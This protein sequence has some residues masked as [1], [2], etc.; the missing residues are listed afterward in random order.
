[1]F[2][3]RQQTQERR[4][5]DPGVTPADRA[6]NGSLFLDDLLD[7]KVREFNACHAEAGGALL[8]QFRHP[9]THLYGIRECV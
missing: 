5:F 1:M 7:A 3:S 6:R 4:G 2:V 9:H 8:G